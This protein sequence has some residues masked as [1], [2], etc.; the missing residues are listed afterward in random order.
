MNGNGKILAGVIAVIT[1]VVGLALGSMRSQ[2]QAQDRFVSKDQYERDIAELKRD[3][4]QLLRFHMEG[5][6]S[7]R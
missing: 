5:R 6:T 4:K 7:G 3:V 2:I 1:L